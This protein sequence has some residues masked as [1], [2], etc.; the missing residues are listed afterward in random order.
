[1]N[2]VKNFRVPQNA[3]NFLITWEVL[4]LSRRTLLHRVNKYC[5]LNDETEWLM[6]V[7]K[8]YYSSHVQIWDYVLESSQTDWR[9]LLTQ[10]N[11]SAVRDADTRPQDYKRAVIWNCYEA[12]C[13]TLNANPAKLFTIREQQNPQKF[14]ARPA[15]KFLASNRYSIIE[16]QQWIDKMWQPGPLMA[17]FSPKIQRNVSNC[18]VTISPLEANTSVC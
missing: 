16:T 3:E 14:S 5:T 2:A 4:S 10:S 6:T 13:T 9:I 7:M 11:R 8:R 17:A 15:L 12:P 1:V 18:R